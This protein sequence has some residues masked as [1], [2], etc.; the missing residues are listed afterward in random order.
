MLKG[1]ERMKQKIAEVIWK[2]DQ[3]RLEIR[4]WQCR[5]QEK[6]YLRDISKEKCKKLCW[7]IKFKSVREWARS[8]G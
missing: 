1:L 8:K 2:N 7:V 4:P 5:Q 6:S 3:D